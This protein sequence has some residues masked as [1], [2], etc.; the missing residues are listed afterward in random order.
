MTRRACWRAVAVGLAVWLAQ[1]CVTVPHEG[2]GGLSPPD[3]ASS[4]GEAT[5][6]SAQWSASAS[7]DEGR[8]DA[9]SRRAEAEWVLAQM[10]AVASSELQVGTVLEFTFW[11]ERG[12]FTLLS[13]HRGA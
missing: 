7:E 11:V 10:W 5:F 3:R 12:A 4:P 8:G 6:V 1:G 13:Q 2:R 9:E